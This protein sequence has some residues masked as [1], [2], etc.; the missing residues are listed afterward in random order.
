MS[1]SGFQSLATPHNIDLIADAAAVASRKLSI[2]S[3]TYCQFHFAS[4]RVAWFREIDD[5]VDV[6]VLSPN[7][8]HAAIRYTC[9]QASGRKISD[10]NQPPIVNV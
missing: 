4:C 7:L 2:H 9:A 10:N 8:K 3:H 5:E 6:S 1:V